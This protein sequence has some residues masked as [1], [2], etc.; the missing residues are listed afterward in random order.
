MAR[1][2]IRIEGW[3]LDKWMG[4]GVER[5]RKRGGSVEDG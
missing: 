4:V 3:G 5:R 2:D 1:V